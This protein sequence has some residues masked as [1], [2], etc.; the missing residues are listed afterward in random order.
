MA[1]T[2]LSDALTKVLNSTAVSSAGCLRRD[3]V[4]FGENPF[5]DAGDTVLLQHIISRMD[6]GV[7]NSIWRLLHMWQGLK[8]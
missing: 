1:S 3:N 5:I 4:T 6:R 7:Q 8:R 2:M